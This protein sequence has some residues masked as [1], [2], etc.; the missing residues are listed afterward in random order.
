[1][2]LEQLY[3]FVNGQTIGTQIRYFV[4]ILSPCAQSPF[5]LA[6]DKNKVIL[7]ATCHKELMCKV[8]SHSVQ[9]IRNRPGMNEWT[10]EWIDKR[11]NGWTIQETVFLCSRRR[12]GDIKLYLSVFY[13]KFCFTA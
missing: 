13:K 7:S 9:R 4:E 10:D 2:N 8:S 6:Q 11:T 12:I 5:F 3:R 1:M